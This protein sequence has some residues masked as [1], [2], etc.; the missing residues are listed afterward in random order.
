M[1]KYLSTLRERPHRHKKRFAFLVSSSVTLAIFLIWTL[2]T[3][4]HGNENKQ[5]TTNN[6]Q[7]EVGPFESL[8]MNLASS[9]EALFVGFNALKSDVESN[10]NLENVGR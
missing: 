9:F 10:L 4:N 2:V 8:K 1:K 3:F 5:L 6:L 7:N